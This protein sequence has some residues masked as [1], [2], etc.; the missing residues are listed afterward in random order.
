MRG[1]RL[2]LGIVILVQAFMQRDVFIGALASFLLFTAVA[3]VGCCGS[4]SC[5]V[6]SK[7]PYE[8]KLPYEELDPK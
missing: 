3:N 7:K 5:S 6:D 8:K 2:A 4:N 1:I